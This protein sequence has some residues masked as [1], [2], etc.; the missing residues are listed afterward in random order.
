M[1]ILRRKPSPIASAPEFQWAYQQNRL[2]VFRYICSL[3]GGPQAEA[4][5]LTAETFL[6]A[7]KARH[8]YQGEQDRVIGWLIQIAKRLVIDDYRREQRAA[9]RQPPAPPPADT[10]EDSAL[11][12]EDSRRLAELL[13]ALPTELREILTLRYSLGWHVKDVAAHMQMTENNVSVTIHRTLAKL[14]QQWSPE[15]E[16]HVDDAE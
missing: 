3:T 5:D 9:R 4:E 16:S 6:R 1:N 15:G 10:P 13:A 7:W 8:R 2:S 11:H 12:N 14:R